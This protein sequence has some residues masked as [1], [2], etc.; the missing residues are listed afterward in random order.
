MPVTD[1]AKLSVTLCL[2]VSTACE[3]Q[4][5]G[6]TTQLVRTCKDLWREDKSL[7]LDHMRIV[8]P[9]TNSAT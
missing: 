1:H 7:R 9:D 6:S 2:H 3:Q 8:E 4:H 5:I